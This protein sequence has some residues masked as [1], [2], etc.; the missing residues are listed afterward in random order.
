MALS[1]LSYRDKLNVGRGQLYIDGEWRDSSDGRIWE[2]VSPVTNEVITELAIGSEEDVDLAVKAARRAFDEGPWPRAKAK[3]RRVAIQ[4]LAELVAAHG[5]ELNQLQTLE[6]GMPVSFSSYYA[7]SSEIA[8]DIFDHHAGWVDKI[9]GETLP[10]YT[11]NDMQVLTLRE[12]VGVVAAIIPWNAPLMLLA[13]KVAPAL[14][15][16][17]TVV[18]KP[19][20]LASLSSVRFASLVAEAGIPEGVFNLVPGPGTPTGEALI[21][22]PLV[23]KVTFT[24]S[25]LV[26]ERILQAS[27]KGLKR[28][29]LELG[30][31][32]PSIFFADVD[33]L[34]LAGMVAMGMV[35]IGLSGQGCACQTRALVER[36]IYDE[37]VEKAA[38]M[39]S[40]ATYGDPFD[41]SVTSA[42]LVSARQVEK[43]MGFIEAGVEQVA[44]LVCGG[45]RP[46]GDLALGNY[47]NPT[48]FA[49]VDNSMSVAQE[50]IFG[51]V[52]AAIPFAD[53]DDAIKIANDT[54]YGLAAGV[55]TNNG[56]RAWRVARAL[57]AGTVGINDYA[58]MP[59]APFGGY[60]QSGVGREGGSAG[61]EAFTEIK[62]VMMGLSG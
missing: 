19:S 47:V 30:G 42:P 43:V 16:G 50:E 57:R 55:Y 54:D 13:Q 31:K 5:D 61:I 12:P 36:S 48:L 28:V 62:T 56:A 8:A 15:A 41:P 49:D 11:G 29:S 17:C 59:N 58:I 18:L 32:S 45:D 22:H 27:G 35:T 25:R 4:R 39:A 53:E 60:K 2:H 38:S 46:G 26:G 44:H 1:M 34:D 20:E 10:T 52:L 37:F 14:A 40:M 9:K 21:T 3:E 7:V 51:P 23:D 6:N 33:S 24:G